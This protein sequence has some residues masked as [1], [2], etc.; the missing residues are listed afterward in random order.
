M[1]TDLE[2]RLFISLVRAGCQ[3]V[4]VDRPGHIRKLGQREPVSVGHRVAETA[5]Q[6]LSDSARTKIYS[7]D[8]FE[9]NCLSRRQY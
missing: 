6:L 7:W 8:R 4:S 2:T 5:F 3:I 1:R 9:H